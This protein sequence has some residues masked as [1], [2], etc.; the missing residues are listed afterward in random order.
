MRNLDPQI[1]VCVGNGNAPPQMMKDHHLCNLLKSRC[2]PPSLRP[3]STLCEFALFRVNSRLNFL[4]SV[5]LRK[6]VP[7]CR[8]SAA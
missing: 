2:F 4:I 5:Y 1:P 7:T 6:P 8:K 3:D